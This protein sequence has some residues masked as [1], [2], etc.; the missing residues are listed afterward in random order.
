M[1]PWQKSLC[2]LCLGSGWCWR[3]GSGEQ[4]LLRAHITTGEG[5]E[6]GQ[7]ELGTC[8]RAALQGSHGPSEMKAAEERQHWDRSCRAV[9][10]GKL[11]GACALWDLSP[12]VASPGQH[13][14]THLV[15][16]PWQQQGGTGARA[17][18]EA[19]SLA[20]RKQHARGGCREHPHLPP[21]PGP[22]AAGSAQ[23]CS[24][25][26][27]SVSICPPLQPPG[28]LCCQ[29]G[30][31]SLAPTA[32]DDSASPEPPPP[33]GASLDGRCSRSSLAAVLG[34]QRSKG[35]AAAWLS[36]TAPRSSSATPVQRQQGRGRGSALHPQHLLGGVGAGERLQTTGASQ[37]RSQQQLRQQQG[38][39]IPC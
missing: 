3:G 8:C 11:Q 22:P 14:L 26:E 7:G 17:A 24:S 20:C 28:G 36:A 2:H 12:V 29:A 6:R 4:T 30:R 5:D 1:S 32:S 23:S 18:K 37:K 35:A 33:T 19:K 39:T 16:C 27:E 21:S 10:A 15:G 31:D 9:A 13:L 38:K 34:S 25:R